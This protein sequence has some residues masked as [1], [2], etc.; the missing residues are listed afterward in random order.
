MT[1][2]SFWREVSALVCTIGMKLSAKTHAHVDKN[3]SLGRDGAQLL[4]E[5]IVRRP[6]DDKSSEVQ[7]IP[8]NA[9]IATSDP[10]NPR[11]PRLFFAV[12]VQC[13]KYIV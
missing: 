2:A 8:S 10:C 7:V 12:Q 9:H 4:E 3:R 13:R 11:D 6:R 5:P 1:S